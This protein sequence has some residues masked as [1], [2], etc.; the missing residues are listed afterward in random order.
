LIGEE[1]VEFDV[2][3][4]CKLFPHFERLVNPIAGKSKAHVR[5]LHDLLDEAAFARRIPGRFYAIVDSDSEIQPDEASAR[6][7]RWDVYHIENYLLEPAYILRVLRD[8]TT[9]ALSEEE[10]LEILGE[11]ASATLSD[12]VG[13][14]LEQI[15]N[16]SLVR[17]IKTATSRGE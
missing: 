10:V 3:M 17:Q 2:R 11:S 15:A 7:F 16:R 8:L 12:L 14:H 13:H 1:D 4:T 5:R 9:S 6:V